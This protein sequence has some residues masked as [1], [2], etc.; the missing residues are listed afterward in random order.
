M[1]LLFSALIQIAFAAPHP[2][3]GSSIVNQ[4]YNNLAFTQMGFK[5]DAIPE[6]WGFNKALDTTGKTLELGPA[7]RTLLSL[8]YETVPAKTNLEQYVRRFLRDYNQYGF[9]VSGLQSVEAGRVPS[10]IVDLNQ[11]NKATRSR[12]VFFNRQNKMVIATCSDE[13]AKFDATLALCNR[14]LGTFDWR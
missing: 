2:L 9:S 13:S 5:L 14:I 6:Y 10:V 8:R 1:V 4:P 7:N 11:K 12:Q 3:T